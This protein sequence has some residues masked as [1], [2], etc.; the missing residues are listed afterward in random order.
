VRAS[1]ERLGV[2]ATND[3]V[4]LYEVCGGMTDMDADYWRLWSLRE[5]EEENS[6]NLERGVLFGDYLINSWCYRLRKIND[7]TSAVYVD[8]FDGTEPEIAAPSLFEF[9]SC[10]LKQPRCVLER[11]ATRCPPKEA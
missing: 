1:F 9:L 2:S 4:A 7:E 8:Y 6:E 5:V 11:R 3:V 10:L